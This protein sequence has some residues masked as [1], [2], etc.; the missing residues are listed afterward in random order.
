MPNGTFCAGES[1]G[2]NIIIRCVNGVAGPGNCNATDWE[3]PDDLLAD[4]ELFW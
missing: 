1:L 2:T 4:I 3:L